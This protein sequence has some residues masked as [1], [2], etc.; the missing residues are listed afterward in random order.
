MNR[1]FIII[2][3]FLFVTFYTNAQVTIMDSPVVNNKDSVYTETGTCFYSYLGS[4]SINNHF[5]RAVFNS[6]FLDDHIKNSN[7]LKGKNILATDLFAGA[8]IAVKPDSLLGSKNLGYRIGYGSRQFRSVRFTDDLYNI[9]FFG[10]KEFAGKSA[11]FNNTRFYL[12]DFQEIQLGLFKDFNDTKTKVRA[13]FG[14]NILKGQ[15]LQKLNL[16]EGSFFT[17]EDGGFVDLDAKYYYYSSDLSHKKYFDFNG[18]GLSC[19][20]YLSIEDV[21]SKTTFTFASKDLGYMVWNNNS[22]LAR[23]DTSYHFEGVDITNILDMG[24]ANVHGLSQDSMLQMLNSTNDTTPFPLSLPER[25]SLEV[26]K[27]WNCR[28]KTSRIGMNYIFDTGQPFPQLYFMQS[29]TINPKLETILMANYGGFS[30]FNAGIFLRYS[31]NK[32]ITATLGSGDISGFILPAEAFAR[33]IYAS[34]IYK[35]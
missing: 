1:V 24:Q 3:L 15:Q 9:I 14:L 35:F 21:A 25:I 26:K 30:Q 19:D 7:Y 10:N 33:S 23:M 12:I 17:A 34:F 20:A 2:N 32:H 28:F 22:F 31:T 16:V 11:N 29:F 4:N 27:E 5:A 8:Y 13:Y 18:I 6:E